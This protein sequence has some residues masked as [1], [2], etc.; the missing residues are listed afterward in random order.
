MAIRE[1]EL[2]NLTVTQLLEL[3]GSEEN[4]NKLIHWYNNK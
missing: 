3:C 4:L 1:S 2:T